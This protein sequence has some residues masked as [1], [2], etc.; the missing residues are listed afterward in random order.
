MD[1]IYKELISGK[2]KAI[3]GFIFGFLA[4]YVAQYGFSLE[5]LTVKELVEQVVYGVIGYV[6]VYLKRNK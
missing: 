6:G 3:V 5:T 4:T 1:F 2:Q